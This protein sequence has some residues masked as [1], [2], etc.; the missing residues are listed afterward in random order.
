MAFCLENSPRGRATRRALARIPAIDADYRRTI[1]LEPDNFEARIDYG[2]LLGNQGKSSEAETQ[3]RKA[4][5]ISPD[6]EVAQRNL[7]LL[8]L[9][10][11]P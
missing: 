11:P 6:N 8:L 3:F 7:R 2:A 10:Q 1:A 5:E 4:L 9:R